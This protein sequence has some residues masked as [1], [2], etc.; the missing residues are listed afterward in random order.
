MSN[1]IEKQARTVFNDFRHKILQDKHPKAI[2]TEQF[3]D[4]M[5]QETGYTINVFEVPMEDAFR[6]IVFKKTKEKEAL[7]LISDKNNLCWK[8]FTVIKELCHVFLSEDYYIES[9][10]MDKIITAIMNHVRYVPKLLPKSSH[11]SHIDDFEKEFERYL[12]TNNPIGASEEDAVTA[13]IEILIPTIQKNWIEEDIKNGI[14]LYDIANQLKVPK[15]MLEN[16]LN[17][18]FIEIPKR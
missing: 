9:S 10:D 17:Q 8:R 6:G 11:M 4:F 2:N 7:I 15:V 12:R 13:T 1:S 14:S 16:R 3:I 5:A 18:W